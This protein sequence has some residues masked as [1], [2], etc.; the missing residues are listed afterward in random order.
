MGGLIVKRYRVSLTGEEQVE[1]NSMVSTGLAA[2]YR[3]THAQ[4]LLLSDENQ[5]ER[6]MMD[7]KIARALGVGTVTTERALHR[8]C[9]QQGVEA[10]I[11]L[12]REPDRRPER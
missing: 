12:K 5:T 1:L 2:A 7:Q 11:G 6:P 8:R 10:A 4:F 9:V 3:Q